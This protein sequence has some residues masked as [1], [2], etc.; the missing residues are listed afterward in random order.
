MDGG[1]ERSQDREH[2]RETRAIK[3][4]DVYRLIA[5]LRIRTNIP[6]REILAI[7]HDFERSINTEEQLLEV[8]AH[9]HIHPWLVSSACCTFE[10]T[11]WVVC[12]RLSPRGWLDQFLS[13]LPENQGGLFPVGVALFHP[14]EQVRKSTAALFDRISKF[15]VRNHPTP[16]PRP[17]PRPHPALAL[18]TH[19]RT[20]GHPHP[21]ALLLTD[22]CLC[23][24]GREWIHQQHEPLFEARIR[25]G[26]VDVR[27]D[28]TVGRALLVQEK[29]IL[30]C[31]RDSDGNHR[32]IA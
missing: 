4:V 29:V 10:L 17:R 19:A 32:G 31:C 16:H 26:Q 1:R 8:R 20:A 5:R 30:L 22:R 6:D 28:C 21:S 3:D 25:R 24:P 27:R 2:F 18:P 12:R 23:T 14:S 7:Y 15:K 11:L 13:Y 9:T